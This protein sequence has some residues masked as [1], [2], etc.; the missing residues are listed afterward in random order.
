MVEE[1]GSIKRLKVQNNINK[2]KNNT[3]ICF[4]TK[5]EVLRVKAD[6]NQ[7]PGWNASLYYT[8]YRK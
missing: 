1:L 5:E 8:Q 2:N 4:E 3:L 7:Y 6:I